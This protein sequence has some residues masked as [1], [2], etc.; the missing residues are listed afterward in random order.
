MAYALIHMQKAVAIEVI[1]SIIYGKHIQCGQVILPKNL[2]CPDYIYP[3]I[4]NSK[5]NFK[6]RWHSN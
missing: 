2:P 5:L 1:I 3:F 6:L 4:P